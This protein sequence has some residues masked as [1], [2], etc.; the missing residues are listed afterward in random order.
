LTAACPAIA[1]VTCAP[2]QQPSKQQDVPLPP[3]SDEDDEQGLDVGEEDLQF[4]QQ[5][6][7]QLGFLRDLDAQQLDK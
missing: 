3:G 2:L 6:G 1:A 7:S 5:Y 4:V